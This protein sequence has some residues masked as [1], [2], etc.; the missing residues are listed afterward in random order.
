MVDQF[1]RRI[2]SSRIGNY[3]PRNWV[4]TVREGVGAGLKFDTHRASGDYHF[5]TNELPV[6][7][8]LAEQLRPGDVFY[9]IGANTGF[10]TMIGARQVGSGG[11][12]YAFEPVPENVAV[13]RH[14]I[15]INGFNH[16]QVVQKAVSFSSEQ[17]QLVLTRH[18][19]G[20]TLITDNPPPDAIGTVTVEMVAL[21]DLVFNQKFAP[22]NFVKIDVEGAELDVLQGMERVMR[23]Y[24]PSL[25]YEIDDEYEDGF[26]RKANECQRHLEQRGYEITRLKDSYVNMNWHVGHFLAIPKLADLET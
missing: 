3:V 18:S 14:N 10:F 21:D 23:T 15:E 17:G 25:L 24:H 11:Q 12:V 19:G 6:Q 13:V 2:L 22:P 5:G 26:T 9:D 16:V 20:A 7:Q 4:V 1:V 8:T